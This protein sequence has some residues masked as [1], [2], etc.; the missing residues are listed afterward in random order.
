[1]RWWI[2]IT[3]DF[4]VEIRRTK[5]P[6]HLI[7]EFNNTDGKFVRNNYKYLYELTMDRK[8]HPYIKLATPSFSQLLYSIR[9]LWNAK[10]GD[11]Y[12]R[13]DHPVIMQVFGVDDSLEVPE[14]VPNREQRRAFQRSL[15]RNRK[16][17]KE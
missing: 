13:R 15:K 17:L 12:D 3:T 4:P 14:H 5:L 1:M 7:D 16:S 8:N 9:T 2:K 10:D 11:P 6:A